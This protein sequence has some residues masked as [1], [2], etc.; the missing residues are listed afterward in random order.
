TSN[1]RFVDVLRDER[2]MAHVFEDFVR[3]FYRVEQNHYHISRDRIAWDLTAEPSS[4]DAAR[5]LPRM[6]TDVTLR[7]S[8]RTLVIEAKYYRETVAQRYGGEALHSHNLYQLFSYLKNLETR[9]GPD[10]QAEGMLLYPKL[11]R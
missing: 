9:V 11:G 6:E 1:F 2:K 10:T 8:T 7:S 3:N 5:L 4:D